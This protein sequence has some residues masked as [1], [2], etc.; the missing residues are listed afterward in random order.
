MLKKSNDF[1]GLLS[2]TG[3][4]EQRVLLYLGASNG[5]GVQ[6]LLSLRLVC[7]TTK[8]WVENLS[9]RF[10]QRVFSRV[11]VRV[12]L[13][14]MGV[15]DYLKSFLESP[16]PSAV[17]SLYLCGDVKTDLPPRTSSCLKMWNHFTDYWATKL[18]SIEMDKFS[19]ERSH[20]IRK[21]L[22]SKAIQNFRCEHLIVDKSFTVSELTEFLF[23][24]KSLRID[25][26][27]IVEE[28]REWFF[29]TL[30]ANKSLRVI[31]HSIRNWD[32]INSI[33]RA[34]KD[35]D[36][37]KMIFRVCPYKLQ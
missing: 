16:P 20:V 7:R 9:P 5:G 15:V 22:G 3:K 10:G 8:D 36:N 21:L 31:D 17:T 24:L 1:R 13:S 35:E 33:F 23:S 2:L 28:K 11:V 25:R 6:G 34:R 4:A 14:K 29:N 12:D 30:F 32:T 19:I 26:L 27:D 37:L 18:K